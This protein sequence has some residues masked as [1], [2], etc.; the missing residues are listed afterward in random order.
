MNLKLWTTVVAIIVVL[1]VSGVYFSDHMKEKDKVVIIGMVNEEGSGLF[2]S[3]SHPGL[4]LDPDTS[5]N[6]GG[7]VFSTPG[8]SSIQHMILMDFVVEHLGMNFAQNADNK[9]SDTVYWTT[10]APGAMGDS[11]VEGIID[12]GIAWEAHYSN[13]CK[14]SSYNAYSVGTTAELWEDHPCCVVA[15]SREFVDSDP[16]AILRFLSA[17]SASVKWVNE[18]INANS[19]NHSK[20]IEYVKLKAGVTNELV[21]QE[22][23]DNV[24]YTFSLDYLKSGIMTMVETYSNLNLLKYSMEEMGF[25]DSRSFADWLV[26]D[27]YINNAAGRAPS[28]YTVL[29]ENIVID[30]GVLANDIHQ[31][32][33]HAGIG[34]GFF[35][36][37]GITLNIGVPFAAGGAV[38]VALLSGQIDIGFVGS[39]PVVLTTVEMWW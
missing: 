10:V 27:S 36:Q 23:L 13:I 16:N 7:L 15:A 2:A 3:K 11:L 34:E 9:N 14:T 31:I 29:G 6:W 30:V 4:S 24:V 20:L 19:A 33:L 12:G 35:D 8:P 38:M 25:A 5:A 39:P 18:A 21:I 28:S 26:D 22:A 17:Y 32:A 1:S 37:Y